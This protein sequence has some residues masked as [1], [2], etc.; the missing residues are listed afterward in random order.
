VRIEVT[1]ESVGEAV[2][3]L[4]GTHTKVAVLNF[5]SATKPGGGFLNGQSAQEESIARS[6][7]LYPSIARHREMY[8]HGAKNPNPFSS[9][10]MIYSPSVPF[11]RDDGGQLLEQPVTA[12]VITAAAVDATR[13][14]DRA[15]QSQIDRTIKNRMRKVIELA[16]EQ[17]N[18]VLVLGA[19]GCGVFG[20]D[21]NR[22]AQIQRELLVDE[23]L[24][25]H[26]DVVVNPI[27]SRGG[28]QQ[29]LQAFRRALGG[30][31]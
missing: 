21:P 30:T 4:S 15:M 16:A 17:Q 29:N 13:V 26:F 25:R 8:E 19:F 20:N 27:M 24:G 9:D 6:S 7:A 18:R 12:S 28:D 1:D 5:A 22:V 31:A 11:F 3:R 2:R 10:Y 23:G 14:P